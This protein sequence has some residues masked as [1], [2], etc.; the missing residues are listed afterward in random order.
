M[1]NPARAGRRTTLLAQGPQTGGPPLGKDHMTSSG[2]TDDGSGIARH[3]RT[4]YALSF[5]AALGVAGCGGAGAEGDVFYDGGPSD[6]SADTG[7][8]QGDDEP[9]DPV[10]PG[11]VV[12]SLE[13]PVPDQDIF[14]LRGTLPLPRGTY[15]ERDRHVP[16]V[17]VNPDG[18][19]AR[20]QV[21]TVTQYPSA[22]D[23]VDVVEVI[24][25][26]RKPPRSETGERVRYDV[27][28][29][30]H[31]ERD[32]QVDPDV[33]SFFEGEDRLVL[34][35]EDVFGN[36][37]S[38]DLFHDVGSNS[39]EVEVMRQGE[40]CKEFRTH[41]ILLPDNPVDGNH[42]TLP[43]MMGVHTNVR[44]WANEKFYSLDLHVH[45]GMDGNDPDSE[46]DDAMQKMYFDALELVMPQGWKLLA[47][48]DHP[49]F[50]APRNE[51]GSRVWP[52]VKPMAGDS[53]HM[54]PMQG[55]F[56]RR[57]VVAKTGFESRA[58][59]V[60]GEEGLAFCVPGRT[61]TGSENWSWWNGDTARYFPQSHRLPNLDHVN[62]AD[63][64]AGL[65]AKLTQY[66][67]QVATGTSGNYPFT[68]QGL[69]WA[70]PWGIQYGGMTGGDEIW[71]YDGVTTA[72][73]CSQEGYRLAQLV[74][75]CYID[76]QPTALYSKTGRPSA[77]SD[78]L[79]ETGLQGPWLPMYFSLRPKLPSNDP[80][81]FGNAPTF[82]NVA[83]ANQGR[84]PHYDERLDDYYAIDLQHY[85]RYTR[86]QKVLIWLGND[87][88][89][90]KEMELAAE[91][92][93]LGFHEYNNS[94]YGHIQGSGLKAKL[95]E[96]A[97][98]PG[99]GLGFGRGESWGTD[100]AL[101]AYATGSRQLRAR[102]YPWFQK[103]AQ[104]LEAG[105]SDCTGCIQSWASTNYL[106]SQYRLRQSYETAIT[107]NAIQGM[108]RT[109]FEGQSEAWA[110]RLEQVIL[111]SA[112]AS[113]SP[114][115]WNEEE[116]AP[117]NYIA[118]G[119]FDGETLY[120]G[121]DVPQGAH[122]YNV[123]RSQYWSSF[124][125][126]YEINQDPEFLLR[127]AQM[128]QTGN[129]YSSLIG[130]GLG[131]LGNTAGLVALV[132]ELELQD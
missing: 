6:G 60:L 19:A 20:T 53:L 42:G 128:A 52:F 89:A 51:G 63:V 8:G 96:T 32:I 83:A 104:V 14:I 121:E 47:A 109:V 33:R 26:V 79:H 46:V 13:V 28:Y 4:H 48:F 123:D 119:S 25:R 130:S 92:F 49:Y 113:I 40:L 68:E 35:T 116:G 5:L 55:R 2:T 122:S 126:A 74:S 132:Q 39:G 73:T 9:G 70:H 1:F 97:E 72:A 112:Y 84:L 93:R 16:L 10:S 86:N 95:I 124:A 7:A 94:N 77:V 23:G 107:E 59:S 45:N 118:V 78:W 82:Q 50:G 76:R 12:A 90:K 17:V 75:R 105:Q 27:A 31:P 98:T 36:S 110:N 111:N 99:R 114:I 43:H 108:L 87:S 125:Y 37:Y 62:T 61:P 81:G 65:S 102:Y 101:T 18:T 44:F 41:E 56:V 67:N 66:S 11:D 54:M 38:A 91:M 106:N 115:F 57:F 71:L 120:C 58:R 22:T 21:E 34:R 103:I 129:L 64:R 127:A 85:I 29:M 24:A 100:A 88:I 3:F 117:W 69:G 30:P 15:H 131:N 80:F